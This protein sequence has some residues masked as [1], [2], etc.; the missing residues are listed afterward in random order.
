MAADAIEMEAV[1]GATMLPNLR[2][3]IDSGGLVQLAGATDRAVGYLNHR[4]ATTG[5]RCGFRLVNS[6]CTCGIANEA[7]AVGSVVYAG[8]SGK[9]TDTAGTL[10]VGIAIS[11]A[12]ADGDAINILPVDG[13]VVADTT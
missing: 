12:L 11:A 8:A 9:V 13:M 2:V 10:I 5:Q 7:I 4:G 6:P 3:K 1:A